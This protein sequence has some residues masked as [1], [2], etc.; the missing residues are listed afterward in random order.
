LDVARILGERL[1][2][3]QRGAGNVVDLM[4]ERERR[5]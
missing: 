5:R 4:K 3:R 1:A 2:E